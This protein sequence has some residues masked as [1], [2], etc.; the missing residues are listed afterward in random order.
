MAT[1]DRHSPALPRVT[2][3]GG[4][5]S[6]RI[7]R[8]T[9]DSWFALNRTARAAL[10]A[11]AAPSD[12]QYRRPVKAAASEVVRKV[13]AGSDPSGDSAA[14]VRVIA[15]DQPAG[16][17]ASDEDV[18]AYVVADAA[19]DIVKD[20]LE[21]FAEA[22]R[23][24]LRESMATGEDR[25]VRETL[26]RVRIQERLLASVSL[27]NQSE[28]C[29]LLGLSKSNPAATMA[30]K[31]RNGEVLRFT[32]DGRAAYPLLQFDVDNRRIYPAMK[33]ILALGRQHRSDFQILRWLTTPHL[34]FDA[35]PAEALGPEAAAVIAAFSREIEVPEHG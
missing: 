17:A 25:L 3:E 29:E 31:E 28:A 30:R 35:T 1:T 20:E 12:A 7:S 27:V 24:M 5:L 10:A 11:S 22:Y 14:P 15:F 2:S 26:N 32:T 23:R 33:E 18:F 8:D 9:L 13:S 19:C 34:D 6:I 4:G 16:H 21:G